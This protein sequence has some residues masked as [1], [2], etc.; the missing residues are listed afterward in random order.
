MSGIAADALAA[1][2]LRCCTFGSELRQGRGRRRPMGRKRVKIGLRG[3]NAPSSSTP[4][5]GLRQT[6]DFTN[7]NRAVARAITGCSRA[8]PGLLRGCPEAFEHKFYAIAVA[9]VSLRWL[10]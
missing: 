3:N 9:R 4:R 6:R 7:N 10:N 8:R 1:A 5:E 2:Q